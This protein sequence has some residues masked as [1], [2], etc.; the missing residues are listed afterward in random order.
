MAAILAC[1]ADAV[2]SHGSAAALYEIDSDWSRGRPRR[3][4]RPSEQVVAVSV[5][6]ERTPK[7]RPG[8][9]IHR[10]RLGPGDTGIYDGIPVTSPARTLIDLATELP[11]D[12]LERAVNEADKLGL[13]DPEALRREVER[14]PGAHGSPAL[15]ALLDRATFAL[16]DS[17]LE[18]RFLPIA[19]RAGLGIP[20]TGVRVNGYVVDF[21]WSELGLV[22]ET[23]GLTYHRT[24]LQQARDRKRDQAHAAAGLTSLRFTHRQIVAEPATVRRTLESVAL[25]LVRRA[26]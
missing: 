4:D 11:T 20:E 23:D 1:G 17:E 22:V 26:G 19:R 25:T 12:R 3:H 7:Q 2:L 14:R 10:A 21:Y 16:T 6:A 5:P 8:L 15:R 13:I 18:R 24:P 9:R